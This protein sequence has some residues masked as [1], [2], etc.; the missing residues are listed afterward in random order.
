[1]VTPLC[2]LCL[3]ASETLF[4]VLCFDIMSIFV[5]EVS[6]MQQ[7]DQSCFTSILLAC[8]FLLGNWVH[9]LFRDFNTQLLGAIKTTQLS[10]SLNW[11]SPHREE[12]GVKS[13]PPM[14]LSENNYRLF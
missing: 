6:Y 12:K 7:N 9:F 10:W 11:A 13:G 1:M 8:F 14:H 2:F 4:P 3:F 5:A